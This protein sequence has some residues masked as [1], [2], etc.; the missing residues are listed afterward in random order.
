M[1]TNENNKLFSI[2]FIESQLQKNDSPGASLLRMLPLGSTLSRNSA[3]YP[4][5]FNR[6]SFEGFGMDRPELAESLPEEL[7]PRNSLLD[8]LMPTNPRHSLFVNAGKIEE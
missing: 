2:Q 4:A 1:H 5:Y 7:W 8:G 6:P 3:E